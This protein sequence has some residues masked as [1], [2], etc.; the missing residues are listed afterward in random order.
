MCL[1]VVIALAND[2]QYGLSASVWTENIGKANRVALGLQVG[3]VWINTWLQRD[4]RV[5]FG[6][7][8]MSGVGREGGKFSLE[9]YTEQKTICVNYT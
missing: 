2:I 1:Y 5:P 7:Q 8:K 4:L 6:G 3:T 9:F